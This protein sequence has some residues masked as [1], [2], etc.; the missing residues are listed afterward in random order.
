[1]VLV[2]SG[3]QQCKQQEDMVVM[4]SLLLHA[5]RRTEEMHC[6][7]TLTSPYVIQIV[8]KKGYMG[9]HTLAAENL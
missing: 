1:M 4:L 8:C 2:R 3:Q 6:L 5:L 9:E 7:C